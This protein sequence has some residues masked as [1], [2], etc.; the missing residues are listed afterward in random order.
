MCVTGRINRTTTWVPLEKTQSVRRVQGPLQRRFGLATVHVD[1]AGKRTRAEF[2]DR[3][4]AEADRLVAELTAL[5]RSARLRRHEAPP[6]A[7]KDDA[8]SGWYPDPAG[9]HELRYWHEGRWTE[10]VADGGRRSADAPMPTPAVA[11]RIGKWSMER[12]PVV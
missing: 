7:A 6:A 4:V 10:H 2:R 11:K 9:R 12:M 3:E 8:P 5:S 1:V